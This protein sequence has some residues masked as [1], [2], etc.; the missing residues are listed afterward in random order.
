MVRV[1]MGHWSNVVDKTVET[2]VTALDDYEKL[3][4]SEEYK[5]EVNS[6]NVLAV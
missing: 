1:R 3:Q 5:F 6:S 4:K 2:L